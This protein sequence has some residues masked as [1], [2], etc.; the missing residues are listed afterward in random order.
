M[1][2]KKGLMNSAKNMP[3]EQ[4]W[5]LNATGLDFGR[6]PSKLSLKF[7]TRGFF[8]TSFTILLYVSKRRSIQSRTEESL[9]HTH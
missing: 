6:N 1:N 8:V 4:G 9:K 3:Y 7:A 2:R 5:T